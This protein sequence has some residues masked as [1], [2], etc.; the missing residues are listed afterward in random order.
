VGE[1]RLL[2]SRLTFWMKFAYPTLWVGL[3]GVGTVAVWTDR[4]SPTPPPR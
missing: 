1:P 2:S 4:M 3:F